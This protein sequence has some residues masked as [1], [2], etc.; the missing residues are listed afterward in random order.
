MVFGAPPLTRIWRLTLPSCHL[1]AGIFQDSNWM[2]YA[3]QKA[4]K[5]MLPG[6]TPSTKAT[7][8]YS[9]K[10]DGWDRNKFHSQCNGYCESCPSARWAPT[11]V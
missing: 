4:L 7:L 2:T 8:L 6:T 3:H 10:S 1:H 5:A 9:A 11:A